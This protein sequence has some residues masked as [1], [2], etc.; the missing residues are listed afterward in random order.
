MRSTIYIDERARLRRTSSVDVMSIR[1]NCFGHLGILW[2]TQR[3]H[4]SPLGRIEPELS[5]EQLS[6]KSQKS[7]RRTAQLLAARESPHFR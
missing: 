6:R 3:T 5:R 1:T 2:T 4:V 7:V